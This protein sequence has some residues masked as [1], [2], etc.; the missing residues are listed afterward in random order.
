MPY[1]ANAGQILIQFI[2]GVLIALV[3]LRVL[4]QLVHANFHN[5]ICQFIYKSTNPV[6]MPLR[7]VIRP[8]RSLDVIG[9]LVCYLLAILKVVLM[10]ALVGHSLGP[11]G[12]LVV[13]LAEML[14]YLLL[15][16]F[17]LIVV[18]VILSYVARDSYSPI[19]P[20][21]YQLTE[22]VL[23]PIRRRLPSLGGFDFSAL[24]ASLAIYLA[25]ALLVQPLTDLG[26][27]LG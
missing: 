4:L 2:F 17:W 20:L 27:Y 13:G 24:I 8:W 23:K 11:V 6:L 10:L 12:L 25:R 18:S 3:G 16:Y 5:P 1:I 22:P 26:L 15:G 9:V 19:V 21:V 14:D 7:R